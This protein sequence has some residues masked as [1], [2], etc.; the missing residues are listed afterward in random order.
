MCSQCDADARSSSASRTLVPAS[1]CEQGFRVST[2]TYCLART[3]CF[4]RRS[5]NSIGRVTHEREAPTD[6]IQLV[7]A[8]F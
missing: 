7:L 6:T 8:F 3:L 5:E 4:S 2:N 1:Y